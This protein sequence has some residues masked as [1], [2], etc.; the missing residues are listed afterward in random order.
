MWSLN[1][2]VSVRTF[3]G[4]DFSICDLALNPNNNQTF[5]SC[6]EV[7]IESLK[8]FFTKIHINLI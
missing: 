7:N 8:I 5:V 2:D 1:E 4:H 3:K 6:S